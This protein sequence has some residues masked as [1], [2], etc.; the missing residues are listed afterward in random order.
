[1]GQSAIKKHPN[2]SLGHNRTIEPR[3]VLDLLSFSGKNKSATG[4]I[5][6]LDLE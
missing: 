5:E 4:R 1:M 2:E 6:E 3:A